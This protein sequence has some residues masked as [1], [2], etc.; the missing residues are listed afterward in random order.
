[1]HFV[2]EVFINFKSPFVLDVVLS[3]SVKLTMAGHWSLDVVVVLFLFQVNLST[4]RSNMVEQLKEPI[5][6]FIEDV[7]DV[8]F[9][10]FVHKQLHIFNVLDNC[11]LLLVLRPL[12]NFILPPVDPTPQANSGVDLWI[13]YH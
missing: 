9:F 8:D 1:M 11:F 13:V 12:L 7:V 3:V 2:N 6:V 4:L 5:V 10:H